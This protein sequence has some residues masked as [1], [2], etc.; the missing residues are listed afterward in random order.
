[1]VAKT[2][3]TGWTLEMRRRGCGSEHGDMLTQFPQFGPGY[4]HFKPY[5]RRWT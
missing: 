5:C 3:Q 4:T 1:M 2:N